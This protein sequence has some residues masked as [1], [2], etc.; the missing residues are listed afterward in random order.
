MIPP[1]KSGFFDDNLH[2]ENLPPN[3]PSPIHA[4]RPSLTAPYPYAEFFYHQMT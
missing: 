1:V 2:E 4:P 3:P